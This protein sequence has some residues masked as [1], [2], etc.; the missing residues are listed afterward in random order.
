MATQK[1]TL[2]VEI[3]KDLGKHGNRRL[4]R[5]GKVPAILY[6]HQKENV[7]LAVPVEQLDAALRH[8]SRLVALTGGVDEE[9]LIRELQWDTWGTHVLHV[10]FTRISADETVEVEVAVE[11]RGEAPG[12]KAGGVIEHLLHELSIECPAGSIPDKIEVNVNLLPLGGSITVAEL[13]LP[14]GVKALAEPDEVVVQCVEPEEVPEEEEAEAGPVEPELIKEKA[15]R[16]G[17]E[18]R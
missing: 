18:E 9:A 17:E 2:T 15:E 1:E 11:L 16:E 12:V 13:G 6:G 10:D 3:R 5:S 7:C 8:G 14:E 4:R